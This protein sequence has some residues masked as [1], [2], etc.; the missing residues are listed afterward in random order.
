M[1]VSSSAVAKAK[2]YSVPLSDAPVGTPS[3][4]VTAA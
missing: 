1:P 3:V 4:N 2:V